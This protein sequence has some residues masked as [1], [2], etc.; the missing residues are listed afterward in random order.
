MTIQAAIAIPGQNLGVAASVFSPDDLSRAQIS[1]ATFYASAG[2]TL[3]VWI[4]PPD[5]TNDDSNKIIE[6]TLAADETYIGAEVI[7]QVV[8]DGGELWAAG[9]N[10]NFV[11]AYRKFDGSS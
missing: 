9:T 6:R 8:E 11:G 3:E 1:M 4:V 7:G 2:A 5:G 10:I